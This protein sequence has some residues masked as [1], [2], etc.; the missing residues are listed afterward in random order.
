MVESHGSTE[1]GAAELAHRAATL[2]EEEAWKPFWSRETEGA[3]GVGEM[4]QQ[5]LLAGRS[6]RVGSAEEKQEEGHDRGGAAPGFGGGRA[7]GSRERSGS[8]EGLALPSPC[9]T[10]LGREMGIEQEA[11]PWP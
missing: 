8:G 6:R 9:V 3:T 5:L 11:L 7:R 10:A 2:Y 1:V 4:L